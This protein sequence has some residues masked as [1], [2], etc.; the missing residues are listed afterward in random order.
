MPHS[1]HGSEFGISSNVNNLNCSR[2][3]QSPP[4]RPIPHPDRSPCQSEQRP[5]PPLPLT[6]CTSSTGRKGSDSPGFVFLSPVGESSDGY[7]TTTNVATSPNFTYLNRAYSSSVE[8]LPHIYS[9]VDKSKK[10][11]NR[12]SSDNA[13]RARTRS[14]SFDD[15]KSGSPKFSYSPKLSGSPVF[16][17]GSPLFSGSPVISRRDN[18]TLGFIS[19]EL[20]VSDNDLVL[21]GPKHPE[22]EVVAVALRSSQSHSDISTAH[23]DKGCST[24]LTGHEESAE[25]QKLRRALSQLPKDRC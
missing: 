14:K 16:G 3:Y 13:F 9:E 19:T 7:I 6:R 15:S 20:N 10:I 5:P 17:G 21:V 18:L 2:N 4:K 23:G 1:S 11:K 22:T 8:V 25:V 12:N 24:V